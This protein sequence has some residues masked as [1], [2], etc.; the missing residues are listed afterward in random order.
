ML[1]NVELYV[2][3]KLFTLKYTYD[4]ILIEL[5]YKFNLQDDRV[6]FNETTIRSVC[7]SKTR[8]CL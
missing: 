7:Y 2:A 1:K 6:K 8:I 5:G 3:N 4:I